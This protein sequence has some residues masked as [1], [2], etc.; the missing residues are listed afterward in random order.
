M[1]IT[2]VV[3]DPRK[4]GK[5]SCPFASFLCQ[6]VYIGKGKPNRY[7]GIL[8]VL[9]GGKEGYSGEMI[10]RWLRGMRKKG[11]TDLPI[12][13]FEHHDE[14]LAFAMERMLTEHFGL[15]KEGGILYNSRHGGDDGWS[16]SEETRKKL[17]QINSGSGNPN[18]GKKWSDK[19]REKWKTTWASKDRSRTPESMSK[20]WEAT[21]RVYKIVTDK[22]EVLFTK[23]LTRFCAE[24]GYPLSTLRNALKGDGVV[25][26]T[27]R[28]STIEGWKI[29]YVE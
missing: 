21:R 28:K 23:D 2:Y 13:V 24:T 14:E 26:S 8:N 29:C 15:K 10:N 27:K 20:A 1:F 16:L 19:Q 17:S 4:P 11:F 6:P 25:R 3:L 22:G 12:V 9:N 7:Q 5:F 18:W